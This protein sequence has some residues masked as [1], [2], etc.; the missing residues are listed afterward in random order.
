MVFGLR[1]E[2]DEFLQGKAKR[3]VYLQRKDVA[4]RSRRWGRG[5][6]VFCQTRSRH[7]TGPMAS[8]H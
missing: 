6:G 8:A 4:P 5:G 3:P 1:L 7:R 2:E